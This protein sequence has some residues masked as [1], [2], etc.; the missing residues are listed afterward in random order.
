VQCQILAIGQKLPEWAAKACEE[1]F[2]RLQRFMKCSLLDIPTATRQKNVDANLYKTEEGSKLLQKIG[3]TDKVIAL[4]VKG[5][6]F[7][8]PELAQNIANW[9]QEG[10]KLVFLIGGPDGLSQ[11]CLA[12]ANIKWSLSALTFPHTLARVILLEQLYRAT[13]LLANHP[14][15]RE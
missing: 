3:P 1:Y 4:D 13:S 14:Y 2:V 5:K 7:S 8:T 6:A 12:R 15:H 10:E 9:Q 11:T